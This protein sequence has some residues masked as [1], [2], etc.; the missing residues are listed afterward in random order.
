[1]TRS[2]SAM[3]SV[4]RASSRPGSA[5][6][7][8]FQPGCPPLGRDPRP[9]R[10]RGRGRD[11][12]RRIVGSANVDIL[13]DL[14]T[15]TGRMLELFAPLTRAASASTC[16]ARCW[17]SPA[18]TRD[19]GRAPRAGPARRHLRAACRARSPTSSPSTRC[20]TISTIRSARSARRRACCGRAGGWLVVDF[21]SHG[22]EFLR[23]EHAHLRLG[24]APEQIA[25]WCG[26][27]GLEIVED[28]LL[29]AARRRRPA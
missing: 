25:E 10:R 2:C 13:L 21:A 23:E 17:R 4:W 27:A 12:D 24:I 18:P 8:L 20:C 7:G 14:G 29:R 15:G 5:P 6:P 11:G 22:L 1:M 28:R 16:G 3:A 26:E 9:A 19:A